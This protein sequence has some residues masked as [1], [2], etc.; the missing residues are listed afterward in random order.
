MFVTITVLTSPGDTEQTADD[1]ARKVSDALGVDHEKDQIHVSVTSSATLPVPPE[2]M[3]AS[4]P[5]A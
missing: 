3:P 1:V 4:P 5:T 2:P